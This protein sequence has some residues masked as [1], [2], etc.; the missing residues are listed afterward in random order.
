MTLVRLLSEE[1]LRAKA[2]PAL[3]LL[4]FGT[5]ALVSQPT[6]STPSENKYWNNPYTHWGELGYNLYG[7]QGEHM[8]TNSC[9]TGGKPT[10]AFIDIDTIFDL[11]QH[12]VWAYPGNGHY[13]Y[14]VTTGGY[15]NTNGGYEWLALCVHSDRRSDD[16][17]RQL[18]EYAENVSSSYGMK[19]IRGAEVQDR[20]GDWGT[21]HEGIIWNGLARGGNET[22]P[23]AFATNGSTDDDKVAFVE[24]VVSVE[25]SQYHSIAVILHPTAGNGGGQNTLDSAT[26][27]VEAGAEMI[28]IFNG[29]WETGDDL[30]INDHLR[31]GSEQEPTGHDGNAENYWDK[32]LSL[33]LRVWGTGSDD[34]HGARKG[35]DLIPKA[36]T[37]GGNYVWIEILAPDN[38]S[39]ETLLRYWEAGSFY[40]TQGV[41][42]ENIQVDGDTITIV[43]DSSVDFIEAIGSVGGPVALGPL[44]KGDGDSGTLLKKTYGRTMTYPMNSSTPYDDIYVRFRLVDTDNDESLWYDEHGDGGGDVYAWTQP[45]F[46]AVRGDVNGDGMVNI[47]DLKLVKLAYSG[48][49]EE[50]NAD[51]DGNGVINIL[52]IK[53]VKL[54]YSGLLPS[55]TP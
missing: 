49:I 53:L 8:H 33:G 10:D 24:H 5:V 23:N 28:E 35:I 12:D 54:I 30:R 31:T 52:D 2:F 16:E 48:W 22:Y 40:V 37:F 13:E 18:M 9:S 21:P 32:I 41:Q 14:N 55:K 29:V 45:F 42:I 43:G 17:Y 11:F 1:R 4:V 44:N 15:P 7:G 51:I 26:R 3:I 50:P 47:L 27:M 46:V 39:S 34:F 36:H 38:A 25:T 19:I 20:E 6:Q